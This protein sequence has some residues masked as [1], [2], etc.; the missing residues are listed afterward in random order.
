MPAALPYMPWWVKDYL[1]DTVPRLMAREHGAYLLLLGRMWLNGGR[2]RFDAAEL[3]QMACVTPAEWPE[4]WT[5]IGPFFRRR[6]SIITQK[7]LSVELEQLKLKAL[8][9]Q[10]AGR[11]GGLATQGK[12]K[13]NPKAAL[14]RP[15][16]DTQA[17]IKQPEPEPDTEP[18]RK[19][20]PTGVGPKKAPPASPAPPPTP[21]KN[22]FA[23]FWLAYPNKVAKRAAE[24]AYERALNRA[25]AETI[26]AGLERATGSRQWG[27]GYIPNPAT[28]LNQDRWTD[29]PAEGQRLLPLTGGMVAAA[30]DERAYRDLL[31]K[32]ANDDDPDGN[33]R[34]AESSG[35]ALPAPANVRR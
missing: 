8:Q 11:K 13:G 20:R 2:L 14:K 17:P 31:E 6:G 21:P 29:E 35:V 18:E 27:E 5:L 34:G 15:A 1:M 4:V 19:E 9:H 28:W 33:P 26:L 32:F 10:Q 16:S 25:D 24:T 30:S 22:G 23:G 7:R 12:R 3:A